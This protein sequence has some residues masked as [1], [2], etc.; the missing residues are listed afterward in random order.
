M[1]SR[2]CLLLALLTLAPGAWAARN[3]PDFT[4]PDS[5]GKQVS[6]SSF[7]GKYVVLN[8]MLTTCPHCQ[9]ATKMLGR[10]QAEFSD[11]LQVLA[12]SG[13]GQGVVA[14]TDFKREFGVTYPVLQGSF[15]VLIDYLGI[16]PV[17]PNYHVPVFF[18]IGP[19]G[20]IL[21]ERN[22]EHEADKDFYANTEQNLEAMVRQAI[23]ADK[24]AAKGAKKEA[25][26]ARKGDRAAAKPS[27]GKA[28]PRGPASA[29]Q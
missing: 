24:G 17:N 2:F 29:G 14:L 25:A 18:L 23:P 12:I 6:L 19:G 21:Q 13:G 20:E 8:I 28:A 10:L 11:K 22:P 5:D 26:P 3:A 1:K 15:K 9:A 16:T 4:L 27:A 7:R